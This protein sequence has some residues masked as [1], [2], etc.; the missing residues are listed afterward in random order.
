MD[1]RQLG[2]DQFELVY[3]DGH[4]RE[5]MAE[6]CFSAVEELVRQGETSHQKWVAEQLVPFL[7]ETAN[8]APVEAESQRVTA[9]ELSFT[10]EALRMY[11]ELGQR[12]RAALHDHPEASGRLHS[13]FAGRKLALQNKAGAMFVDL[14]RGIKKPSTAETSSTP[15]LTGLEP[16]SS[17]AS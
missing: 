1:T 13:Q 6:A 10:A 4:E 12:T 9:D 15:D 2:P 8:R 7:L 5:A 11:S 3:A 17:L 14:S 16:A